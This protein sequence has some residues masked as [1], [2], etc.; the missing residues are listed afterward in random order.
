MLAF[1]MFDKQS[2]IPNFNAIQLRTSVSKSSAYKLRTKTISHGWMLG[3][4]VEPK[5]VD[6][7]PHLGRPKTSTVTALC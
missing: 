3:D 1:S 5:H 6:D 7:A 4:I 2:P